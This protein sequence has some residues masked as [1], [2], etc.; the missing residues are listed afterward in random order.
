MSKPL[1]MGFDSRGNLEL[2]SWDCAQTEIAK[3]FEDHFQYL[4]MDNGTGV[5]RVYWKSIRTGREYSMFISDFDEI[6]LAKAFVNN[7]ITG[8]FRFVKRGQSQA[9][10]LILEPAAKP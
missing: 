9:I 5:S 1:V 2:R 10:K 4:K 8:T 3:D 6:I 7:Q